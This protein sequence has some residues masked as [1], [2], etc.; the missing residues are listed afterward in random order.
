MVCTENW[1]WRH[2]PTVTCG[3]REREQRALDCGLA[4]P[5]CLPP[6]VR[7]SCQP[8]QGGCVTGT[9]LNI[10]LTACM[11]WLT[12]GW[13]P[14]QPCRAI[15]CVDWRTLPSRKTSIRTHFTLHLASL[16]PRPR[17]THFTLKSHTIYLVIAQTKTLQYS[18]NGPYFSLVFCVNVCCNKV[19]RDQVVLSQDPTD[20]RWST[21]IDSHKTVLLKPITNVIYI[22]GSDITWPVL[23]R[24]E[25][26]RVHH[27]TA[28]TTT[29]QHVTQYQWPCHR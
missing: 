27:H 6:V 22:Y 28:T 11:P 5:S 16:L 9:P 19:T 1:Y 3:G 29:H 17:K 21:D 2:S 8:I 4:R 14:P 26:V 20:T 18:S 23:W 10:A 24:W 7:T 25:L 12:A 15:T 13:T